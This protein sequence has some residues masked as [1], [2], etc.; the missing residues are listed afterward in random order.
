MLSAEL[1]SFL[2]A[3]LREA[4]MG[5]GPGL[6][7]SGGVGV[8]IGPVGR[9]AQVVESGRDKIIKQD[10]LSKFKTKLGFGPPRL[11]QIG[12]QRHLLMRRADNRGFFNL[13][14]YGATLGPKTMEV[15]KS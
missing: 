13:K 9:D 12:D 4:I 10:A 7:R 6:I 5:D 14:K 3:R 8:Q 1:I 2:V 15:P 11:Q